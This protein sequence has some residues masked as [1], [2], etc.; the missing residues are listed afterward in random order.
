M[1]KPEFQTKL[2]AGV[3]YEL[4]VNMRNLRNF[5]ADSILPKIES[6]KY[7]IE[8]SNFSS[9]A[10]MGSVPVK[11]LDTPIEEICGS[12]A[13]MVGFGSLDT[14]NFPIDSDM[15]ILGRGRFHFSYDRFSDRYFGDA[16]YIEPVDRD[17][18]DDLWQYCFGSG[19]ENDLEAGIERLDYAIEVIDKQINAI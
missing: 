6:G 8:M 12:C 11:A 15:F 10:R 14:E 3:L 2:S 5:L 7:S 18:N 9:R 1:L 17:E 19:N 4:N 16:E 13:C